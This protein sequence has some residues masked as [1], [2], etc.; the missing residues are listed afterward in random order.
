MDCGFSISTRMSRNTQEIYV[1]SQ[2]DWT[3]L[4]RLSLNKAFLLYCT[5][6]PELFHPVENDTPYRLWNPAT[7]S[8]LQR[9]PN[10]TISCNGSFKDMNYDSKYI[11]GQNLFAYGVK[12]MSVFAWS[13]ACNFVMKFS[14][15]SSLIDILMKET[16]ARF[17]HGPYSDQRNET[18][19]TCASTVK[20][21]LASF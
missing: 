19:P 2:I 8:L 4:R 16:S 1:S 11:I 7:T 6:G 3:A 17:S 5:K 9:D 12:I 15:N 18:G 21:K 13:F 10:N 14:S 20:L